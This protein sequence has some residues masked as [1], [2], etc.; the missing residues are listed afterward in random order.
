MAQTASIDAGTMPPQLCVI[1]R[2]ATIRFCRMQ[3]S[4]VGVKRVATL[5]TDTAPAKRPVWSKMGADIL[6]I[7]SSKLRFVRP[8]PVSR[9]DWIA[10]AS[11]SGVFTVVGVNICKFPHA[12]AANSD[13]PKASAQR[14]D[15][16]A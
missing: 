14:P 4:N 12:M 3:C 10:K 13:G 16:V 6:Q 1:S 7:S 5:A 2:L 8:N 11:S 9:T 15:A